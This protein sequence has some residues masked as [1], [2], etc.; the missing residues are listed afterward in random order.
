MKLPGAEELNLEQGY[1][2]SKGARIRRTLNR[3]R[4]TDK[5]EFTFK[6]TVNGKQIEI[7]TEISSSDYFALWQTVNR[8][9]K[10]T[11]IVVPTYSGDTWEVDFFH[12]SK[13]G[14][15]YLVMA[16]VE[17]PEDK[18]KPDLLPLFISSTLLHE[19]EYGDKRFNSKELTRPVSVAAL[20]QKIRNGEL[21]SEKDHS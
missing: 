12:T 16:E 11:R 4:G 10:K 18:Q 6:Q 2:D 13:A 8:I 19:V 14:E 20:L 21:Q 17:L 15:T 9:V 1:L 7:E 5:A 3:T